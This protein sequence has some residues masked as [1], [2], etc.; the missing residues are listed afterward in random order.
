MKN[1][2]TSEIRVSISS[3]LNFTMWVFALGLA[4]DHDMHKKSE[5]IA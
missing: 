3:N 1:I 2:G 4:N 5:K